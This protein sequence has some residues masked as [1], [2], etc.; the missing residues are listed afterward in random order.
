MRTRHL[1]ALALFAAFAVVGGAGAPARDDDEEHH[2]PPAGKLMAPWLNTGGH[3]ARIGEMAFAK[4]GERLY[5]VG[6]PGDVHE[7][8]AK[9]GERLRVWRF[10]RMASRLA[11]T[12][13]T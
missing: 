13:F 9:T 6:L 5:T 10:P 4:G 11:I 3:T 12:H 8:D 7:W 1:Q 2:E